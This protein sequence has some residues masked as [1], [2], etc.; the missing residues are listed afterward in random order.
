MGCTACQKQHYLLDGRCLA[1]CPPT[2]TP[3]GEGDFFR[4][5]M[6]PIPE[7]EESLCAKNIST[8]GRPCTCPKGCHLCERSFST[9]E[10]PLCLGC[11]SMYLHEGTCVSTCPMGFKPRSHGAFSSSC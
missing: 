4:I 9:A 2:H 8:S 3:T 1:R 5:C 7:I 10:N 11:T 6:E